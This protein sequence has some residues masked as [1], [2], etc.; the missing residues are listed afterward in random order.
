MTSALNRDENCHNSSPALERTKSDRLLYL[1]ASCLVLLTLVQA[2]MAQTTSPLG[3]DIVTAD[4]ASGYRTQIRQYVQTNLKPIA[5]NDRENIARSRDELI[6]AATTP[7]PAR[8]PSF[9]QMFAQ[10]LD[11]QIRPQL[12]KASPS[13]RVNF[14]IV[15]ARV[16]RAG[17]SSE[18][19][20]TIEAL[21]ADESPAVAIWGLQAARFVLPV[22]LDNAVL[23]KG[24]KII[25]NAAQAVRTHQEQGPLAAEAYRSLLGE[26]EAITRDPRKRAAQKAMLDNISPALIDGVHDILGARLSVYEAN[27]IPN[28]P[29]TD[30]TDG[31]R[32]LALPAVWGLQSPDQRDTTMRRVIQLLQVTRKHIDSTDA[33]Q[34]E[35][36]RELARGLG[37][38]CAAIDPSVPGA[39]SLAKV[40]TDLNRIGRANPIAQIQSLIDGVIDAIPLSFPNAATQPAPK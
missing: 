7:T 30:Y 34:I 19:S 9:L 8:S 35:Q 20:R 12:S 38:V 26:I 25:A 24:D 2:G 16:A 15:V 27:A 32:A 23:S 22:V 39:A 40:G 17:Q 1:L 28:D 29:L 18:L 11:A 13:A 31:V 37:S 5:A 21:I 36:F 14:A 10:E 6:N 4:D 33:A 3:N